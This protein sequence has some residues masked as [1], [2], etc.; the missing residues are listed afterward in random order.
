[1]TQAK[2]AGLL[3]RSSEQQT[4]ERVGVGL[5]NID[6]RLRSV[7]GRGLEIESKV[8]SGTVV[9]FHILTKGH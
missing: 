8:G 5:S 2:L 9:S 3:N 4:E 1:M 7:Y 6:R